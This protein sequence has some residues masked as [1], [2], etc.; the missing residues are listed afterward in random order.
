VLPKDAYIDELT[1][2][3]L[4]ERFIS[5]SADTVSTIVSLGG[6]E[7]DTATYAFSYVL[8]HYNPAPYNLVNIGA[9][10]KLLR[11]LR[12]CRA[13][14]NL[15]QQN[16]IKNRRVIPDQQEFPRLGR[17]LYS[18]SN[19]IFAECFKDDASFFPHLIMHQFPNEILDFFGV[20]TK[21]TKASLFVCLARLEH[22]IDSAAG[23]ADL[24]EVISRCRRVWTRWGELSDRLQRETW[25]ADD[26]AR[27]SRIRCVPAYKAPPTPRYRA[28]FLDEYHDKQIYALSEVCD[29]E[30]ISIC[31]TQCSFAATKPPKH[32]NYLGFSPSISMV[33]EHLVMLATHI[34]NV[35]TIENKP[36]FVDLL[37]TYE[38]IAKQENMGAASKLIKSAHPNAKIWLNDDVRLSNITGFVQARPGYSDKPISS[39]TWLSSS[40]ILHGVSYDLPSRG[41]YAAKT[42]LEPYSTLLRAC[43]SRVV[44]TIKAVLQDEKVEDHGQLLLK[45]LRNIKERQPSLCDIQIE[46]DGKVH[47]AHRV[48]LAAVSSYFEGLCLGEWEEKETGVLKLDKETYGTSASVTSV[49]EWAYNGFIE[50][51]DGM[52]KKDDLDQVQER[53]DHYLDCL[54]LGNVWDVPEFRNHVENRILKFA[55]LFIRIENV[56]VVHEMA[57]RY[58]AG[59]LKRHCVALISENKDIV[60]LVDNTEEE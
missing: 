48:I 33:V 24:R 10:E 14:C 40:S 13:S 59:A 22:A 9:L 57:S 53:L 56:S 12:D 3:S 11:Q 16:L 21:L 2:A 38:F 58:Q 29:P 5:E 41:M 30:Y 47:H 35:T 6:K 54:E 19:R 50:L 52:L 7:I 51:D 32:L 60:N 31:W 15:K 46:V 37:E 42:S 55:D 43:G 39:L 28:K 36:F 49:L 20:Q 4:K 27:I 18:R 1:P 45:R 44:S 34:A 17:D 8:E 26:F 23:E 25:S